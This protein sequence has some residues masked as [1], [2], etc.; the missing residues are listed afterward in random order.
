MRNYAQLKLVCEGSEST[1]QLLPEFRRLLN[2]R[3]YTQR[4]HPVLQ[5][6]VGTLSLEKAF[7][8]QTD[9]ARIFIGHLLQERHIFLIARGQALFHDPSRRRTDA[10]PFG[11]TPLQNYVAG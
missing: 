4:R 7:S 8:P 5:A 1:Q 6:F 3:R 9:I 2:S 11:T 10:A